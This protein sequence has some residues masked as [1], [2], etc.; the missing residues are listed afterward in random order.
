MSTALFPDVEYASVYVL[1]VV[2]I[3]LDHAL[4][5]CLPVDGDRSGDFSKVSPE[6]GHSILVFIREVLIGDY[7]YLATVSAGMDERIGGM[8]E[9][10]RL[11]LAPSS[12]LVDKLTLMR[13][14]PDDVNAIYARDIGDRSPWQ[15][16][17]SQAPCRRVHRS[18]QC[19]IPIRQMGGLC[20]TEPRLFRLPENRPRPNSGLH[21][22]RN[23]TDR[24]SQNA[25]RL[26]IRCGHRRLLVG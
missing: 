21:F 23:Q 2:A 9:A 19:R 24:R 13:S 10:G 16:N 11:R 5:E 15:L 26:E 3:P 12:P 14:G 17:D 6:N 4:R 25:G 22:F 18:D 8:S 20:R 7:G 1:L